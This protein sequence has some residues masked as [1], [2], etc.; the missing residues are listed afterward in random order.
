MP[1]TDDPPLRD[2]AL[3]RL[4]PRQLALRPRAEAVLAGLSPAQLAQRPPGDGW[5]IAEALEHLCL[6]HLP[7]LDDAIPRAIARAAPRRDLD[8]PD[9]HAAGQRHVT[10]FLGGLL[11][12]AVREDSGRRLPTMG[13]MR[14]HA[15][16]TAIATEFLA[17]LE[18]LDAQ[19][20]AADGRDLNTR[21]RSPFAWWLWL[22][23]GDALVMVTEHTHRHLA[24]AERCR[25]ALGL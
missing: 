11:I 5:S 13:P 3:Q 2:E 10:S 14:V 23:L 1:A 18:R 17:S 6:A 12:A 15:V 21:L 20:R 22:N 24:Q 16:R 19:V 8:G 4:R 9:P 7:Y 25:R